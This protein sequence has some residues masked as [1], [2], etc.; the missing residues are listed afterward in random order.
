MLIIRTIPYSLEEMGAILEIR[1][2]AESIEV[3]LEELKDVFIVEG[4]DIKM[5]HGH[6][7]AL[8]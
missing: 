2:Q 6:N 7:I 5:M 3:S 8:C 1:S 4:D